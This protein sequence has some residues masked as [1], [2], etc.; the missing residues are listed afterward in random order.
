[1]GE[2]MICHICRQPTEE[3]FKAKVLDKYQVRYFH[4]PHCGFIQTETPTWIEEAYK[5]PINAEDTGL[6]SRNIFL[7]EATSLLLYFLFDR[8]KN[9]LDYAGG[10]GVFTRLMRDIG[11][12]F[13]WHDPMTA[14]LL[15][16]GFEGKEISGEYEVLTTFESFEHFTDP[17]AELKKML[18]ITDNIL[19]STTLLPSSVPN[20]DW[21]YYQFEH[22]QHV[23]FY[24]RESLAR[25]AQEHG[26]HF[27]TYGFLHLFTKKHFPVSV[28]RWMF[29]FHKLGLHQYVRRRMK[30]K[31][32]DDFLLM[33]KTKRS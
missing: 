18:S 10:F 9:F 12:N 33:L 25:L 17:A 15:A 13:Y 23:S 29:R 27:Y 22:G 3:A 2:T 20:L 4:C 21:W 8:E 5:D 28:I 30:S 11:F 19:F 6:L 14:N 24:S 16:K 32:H 7:S 31:M 26:L 1:M